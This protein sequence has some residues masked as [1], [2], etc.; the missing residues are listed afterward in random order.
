MPAAIVD[1][2]LRGWKLP[3]SESAHG[4]AH[5]LSV[6]FFGVKDGR[7]ANRAEPEGEPR[8]LIPDPNMFG[9]VAI[10]PERCIKASERRENA[11]GSTLAGEA[12]ADAHAARLALDL[13][14]QLP[15][16]TGCGSGR[17]A[18]LVLRSVREPAA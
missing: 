16:G 2:P 8:A 14:A 1:G 7:A 15:A 18:H 13:N 4:D 5:G 3:V 17:H 12:V 9:G 10:D 11:A 6:A